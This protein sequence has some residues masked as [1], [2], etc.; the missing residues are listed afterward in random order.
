MS[1]GTGCLDNCAQSQNFSDFNFN[2]SSSSSSSTSNV[3]DD[4]YYDYSDSVSSIAL[5]EIIPGAIVYGLTLIIGIIGNTLVI[6]SIARYRRM[7]NITNTF[8]LSLASADLLLVLICVPVKFA[9]FFSFTWTFGEFL[10]KAVVYL[11]NVSAICSVF[12]LTAIS[13]ER[14]YAI[15]HPLR[16]KYVCTVGRARKAIIVLWFISI[17]LAIPIPFLQVHKMV[18]YIR[19]GY[20]CVKDWEQT[21][22]SKIYEVY[23]F[24]I[25]LILPILIMIFAYA[26]ICIELWMVTHNRQILQNGR[27]CYTQRL[28]SPKP[29]PFKVTSDKCPVMRKQTTIKKTSEDDSTRK[30]VIKMLVAVIII[31]IVCWAPILTN[32]LLTS[33]NVLHPLNYGYL[34]PMRLAFYLL[35]YANSCV[36]PIIYGF[37][38]KKFRQTFYHSLCT[39]IRGKEYVRRKYFMRQNSMQTRSTMY[40]YGRSHTELEMSRTCDPQYGSFQDV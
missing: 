39:C 33:F 34:K 10:C 19:I 37:M 38:S 4:Y 22:F 25:M 20:W 24:C 1:P 9:A 23:M 28:A 16:A 26:S 2:N 30:Q 21:L 14:Y 12:T 36:N 8:L 32:N 29:S 6:F 35:S 3:T 40:A 13:L 31:F 27:D 11:Q 5:Q 7:K 15:L 17:V 18:G